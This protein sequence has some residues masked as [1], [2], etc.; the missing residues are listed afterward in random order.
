[1]PISLTSSRIGK[2]FGRR[3][4]KWCFR[5]PTTL[6]LDQPLVSFTFDDFPRSALL[7]GGRLLEDVQAAGTYFA[8]F[9]LMGK[10][11]PTGEIFL[12][13]DLPHLFR[14]GHEL[15]CHTFDH[16]PAWETPTAPYIAAVERNLQALGHLTPQRQ[17]RTHS[18]PISFP[19]PLTK[20]WLNRRF[21]ACRGG[22]QTINL[23]VLDLGHLNSFFIEQSRENTNGIQRIIEENAQRVGWLIFSTHDVAD[24]PTPYGCTPALFARILE[25]T[26]ASGARITTV[27]GALTRIRSKS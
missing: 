23:N 22:G 12:E 16:F 2:A 4:A 8:S 11:A 17:F 7:T 21:K 15:A 26:V 24:H 5:K 1:M 9:G 27:D 20:R 13:H 10:S 18:F 19:R 14:G 3:A 25:W 6:R